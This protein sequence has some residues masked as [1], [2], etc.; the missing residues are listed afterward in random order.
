MLFN[1]RDLGILVAGAIGAVLALLLPL[2]LWGSMAVGVCV[3][4]AGMLFALLRVGPDKVPLEQWLQRRLSFAF[5][6]RRYVYHHD[7]PDTPEVPDSSEP[8][9]AQEA[10]PQ[11]A[12]P[13][14]LDFDDVGI[15]LLATVAMGIL[16][17]YTYVWLQAGGAEEV[18]RFL[19]Y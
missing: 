5:K 4:V 19:G 10:D 9:P 18:A 16:G 1:N 2:P 12:T 14:V 7:R 13:M 8:Q 11:P 3:L 6:T 15:E 17:F